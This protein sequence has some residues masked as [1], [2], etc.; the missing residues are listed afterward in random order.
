MDESNHVTQLAETVAG[1]SGPE[2]RRIGGSGQG[3]IAE[4][5]AAPR[6]RAETPESS[7]EVR[8]RDW[9]RAVDL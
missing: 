1:L 9:L 4:G 7:P 5:G 6:G 2:A 3:L 8:L